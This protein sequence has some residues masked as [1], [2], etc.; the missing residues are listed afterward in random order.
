MTRYKL[1]YFDIDGGRGEPLRIAFNAAGLDFEDHRISFGDF[2]KLRDAMPFRCAPVL[3]VDGIPVTQSNAMLRYVGK[4]AGLYPEDSLQALYCDETMDAVEDM[5]HHIVRT[6]GL[7]GEVLETARKELM[8]GWL[9]T[10]VE[11]FGEL[12]KRGGGKYFADGRLTVADL[13]VYVQI[14]SLRGGHLDHV[15]ADF[16]DRLAPGLAEH[17]ERIAAEP[18][19][20][21][22]YAGRS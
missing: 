19:V 20:R 3:E 1:T 8:D 22:Y 2:M 13:K 6:F 10:F 14:R 11:G 7:E 21:D 9:R 5:L 16:V 18:I 15:P 17:Q 12:L 4:L